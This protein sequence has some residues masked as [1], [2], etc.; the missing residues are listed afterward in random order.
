MHSDTQVCIKHKRP[1]TS[2]RTEKE[3]AD[4][5]TH[6]GYSVRTL[7]MLRRNHGAS[8]GQTIML[9]LDH[10]LLLKRLEHMLWQRWRE[11]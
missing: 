1:K 7:R 11:L 10:L 5:G 6:F 8:I 4:Q 9:W 2:T 3:Q